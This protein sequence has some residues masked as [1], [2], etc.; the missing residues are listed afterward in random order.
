MKTAWIFFA[1]IAMIVVTN[2]EFTIYDYSLLSY[3]QRQAIKIFAN[4]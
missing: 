2:A 3:N 4:R 1:V